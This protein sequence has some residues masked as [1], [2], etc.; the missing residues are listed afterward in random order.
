MQFATENLFNLP[1]GP[2]TSNWKV[3]TD[4]KTLKFFSVSQSILLKETEKVNLS[5]LETLFYEGMN[6]SPVELTQC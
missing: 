2:S 3:Y 1:K 5:V 6:E 4:F